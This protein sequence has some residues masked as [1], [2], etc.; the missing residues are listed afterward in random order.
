VT[1]ISCCSAVQTSSNGTTVQYFVLRQCQLRRTTETTRNAKRVIAERRP[2]RPF[3]DSASAY[4]SRPSP[5]QSYISDNSHSLYQSVINPTTTIPFITTLAHRHSGRLIYSNQR[6]LAT[7][8]L[9]QVIDFDG[10]CLLFVSLTVA[11]L[12]TTLPQ[13]NTSLESYF[14]LA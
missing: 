9:G 12:A 4:S 8:Q 11:A 14:T 3:S 10:C 13:A 5:Y 7:S 1:E 6:R 2:D